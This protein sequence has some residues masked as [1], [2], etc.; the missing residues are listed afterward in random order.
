MSDLLVLLTND[1]GF[2]SQGIVSLKNAISKIGKAYIIAPNVE[3]STTG[4]SLSIYS[5]VRVKKEKEEVYSVDGFPVDCVYIGLFGGILPRKPDFVI[6]GINKGV[7]MSNDVYYS[8]TVAATRQA[9]MSG[10][11]SFSVSLSVEGANKEFFWD[12]A[13]EFCVDILQK[14]IGKEM[15]KGSFLNINYPNLP[16]NEIKGVRLSSLGVRK[17]SEEVLWRLDPRA[18]KYCWLG[19]IYKGFTY[20]EGTDCSAID[21]G[22]I[23]ITPM[24]LDTTDY[25]I[26][27]EVKFLIS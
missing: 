16:K 26:F 8:G 19:G 18:D 12:D 14:L 23:S 13:A 17:Y 6:S 21:D 10:T 9:V 4:Q 15:K 2:N 5:P 27:D 25:E 7:N 11:A 24:K 20:I 3:K 22:Y 1:D